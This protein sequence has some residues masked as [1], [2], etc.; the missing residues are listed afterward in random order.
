MGK[1]I[2]IREVPESTRNELASRAAR[3]GRSLQEFL[4]AE[5]VRLAQRPDPTALLSQV[6]ERKQRSGSRLP[7][8]AILAH[9]DADRR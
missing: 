9:R 4:R 8:R 1:S 7:A 2:T 5:L 3:S 6:R